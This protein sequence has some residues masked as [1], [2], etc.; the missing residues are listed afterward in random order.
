MQEL[1]TTRHNEL[2]DPL[3]HIWGWQI[4]TYL[5]MGGLVAGIMIISGY[6]VLQGR[7][8]NNLYACFYLP[9]ISLCLLS[10]GMLALFLDLEHK[11]FT[12]RLYTT[13][14][15]S[16]PMSWGSWIL[17]LIYPALLVNL[18]VRI[19]GPLRNRL[20]WV[21]RFS[22]AIN[23][24]PLGVKAIGVLNMVLGAMLGMYTGVLLSALGARPLWNSAMLWILFLV[25]GLS[26]AAAF[27]HMITPDK[28][29]RELLA[30]ADNGFLTFELLVISLLLVG[31]L[32]S[33][34]VHIEAAHLL[35]SGQFAPVFWVFVVGLGIIIPLIIQLLAVNHKV[36]HTPIAPVLVILGG[37]ILRF[38]IVYAGQ[39]SHW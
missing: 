15:A 30:K 24:H 5:F 36:K 38:V 9:I 20:P 22:R 31:L 37:L 19:P 26:A 25:S 16:S 18:L 28:S 32:S 6:F 27:V 2:V 14:K 11:W 1:T 3:L 10:L 35:L 21:D 23:G 33:T 8:K 34:R 39:V 17:V 13:F 12:W 29:E 7:H 4:P